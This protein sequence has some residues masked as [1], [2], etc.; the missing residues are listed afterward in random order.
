MNKTIS[1][2]VLLCALAAGQAQA[3]DTHGRWN[4]SSIPVPYRVNSANMPYPELV[5]E[6]AQQWSTNRA[7]DFGFAY[8][9]ATQSSGNFTVHMSR[10]LPRG[11]AGMT[12]W[13]TSRGYHVLFRTGLNQTHR[14]SRTRFLS[15]TTHELGHA[16]GLAH[17]KS[18]SAVMWFAAG[19]A[20]ISAD[21]IA[22]ARRL[23]PPRG[24][25]R[26]WDAQLG[27]PSALAPTGTIQSLRPSF[28]WVAAPGATSYEI[29][30][31]R[32][33]S[34]GKQTK[35]IRSGSI[36]GTS[37]E[38]DQPLPGKGRYLFWVRA[39][40]AQGAG[41][42]ANASFELEA[43]TQRPGPVTILGPKGTVSV[44]TPTISFS[45]AEHA[46][47]HDIAIDRRSAD[48][49]SWTAVLRKESIEDNYL[50]L[51]A[52][53]RGQT[54]RVWVRGRNDAGLGA[55]SQGLNFSVAAD[56]VAPRVL[57]GPVGGTLPPLGAPEFTVPAGFQPDADCGPNG[58]PPAAD[59][60]C[61]PN[62]CPPAADPNCGPN[63]CPPAAD[64]NCGP[65]G[66]PPA[67]DPNCGPNGCPPATDPNC[68][69]NGCPPTAGQNCGPRGCS[70][71]AGRA[72]P[73]RGRCKPGSCNR[74][75]SK[76]RG[77]FGGFLQRLRRSR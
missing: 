76:K 49:K 22:G 10:R 48:G 15:V 46:T 68:G 1:L 6:A 58:C 43:V 9:G 60:N 14:W 37:F 70:P 64:P 50:E 77:M 73:P 39:K 62:G 7:F 8:K 45:R 16:L 38:L 61:G 71:N 65:N 53:D 4:R 28:S 54:Y 31:D 67:A 30:I 21:D 34:S 17:S 69:P 19:P 47:S 33:D 20:R 2:G 75:R 25:E 27:K 57:P 12:W 41:E 3:Y 63:G 29:A 59:P 40:N 66:C 5:Q 32:V 74:S 51:A 52:L 13:N 18:R 72:C 23:Y 35:L 55:Y 24:G 42:Y 26:P 36:K 11:V 56:A 44:L